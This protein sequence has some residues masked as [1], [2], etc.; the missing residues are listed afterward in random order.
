MDLKLTVEQ[1]LA[2]ALH[3]RSPVMIFD[4]IFSALDR[5][6]ARKIFLNMFSRNGILR[7]LNTTV[8]LATHS[9]SSNVCCFIGEIIPLTLNYS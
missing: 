2:R 5:V 4:D 1:A 8:I 3:S 7:R 6:T 9:G